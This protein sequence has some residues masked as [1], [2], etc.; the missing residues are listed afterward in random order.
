MAVRHHRLC[1]LIERPR[2]A[3]FLVWPEVPHKKPKETRGTRSMLGR[4]QPREHG[5]RQA[6]L[7][8]IWIRDVVLR[9]VLSPEELTRGLE[10]EAA[11]VGEVRT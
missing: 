6:H 4:W 7:G 1:S 3:G 11:L 5:V 2:G 8:R 9:A 10:R